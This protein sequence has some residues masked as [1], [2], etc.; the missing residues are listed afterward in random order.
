MTLGIPLATGTAPGPLG[1]RYALGRQL[2]RGSSAAVFEATD[3]VLNRPVTVK[4][5]DSALAREP[6]L[7]ARFGEQCAKAA[8]LAHPHIARVLDAGFA[9]HPVEQPFVVTEP[10][11]P[12]SL[13]Q[14]LDGEGRLPLKRAVALARQLASALAYAHAQGLVHADVKPENVLLDETGR[15]AKLVDFSLSFVSAATGMVTPATIA[16]RAAYLAPEQVR[17]E[18]VRP[19]TD[20]YGLGVLL[21]EMVAGRPPFRAGTPEATAERRIHEF[22]PPAGNFDPAIPQR[23]EA[24]LDRALERAP[25]RRWR[26]MEAFDAALA[27]LDGASL[28]PAALPLPPDP[29][30]TAAATQA[31]PWTPT[32][33]L[34]SVV[35]VAVGL[36]V[37]VLALVV[38]LRMIGSG[39]RLSNLLSVGAAQVEIPDL[40]GMSVADAKRL[41]EPRGYTFQVVGERVSDRYPKGAIVQQSPVAGWQ[42]APNGPLRV[43]VSSGPVAP[44]PL[45]TAAPAAGGTGG[46]AAGASAGACS[47]GAPPV[48][49]LGFAELK[50][51]VGAPMG[52]PLEC[53][54]ANPR[55]GDT[56]QRT[57][58][59][60][61]YYR[62]TTNLVAFTDG[63]RHWALTENGLVTWEG[64][65]PDPPPAP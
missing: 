12:R 21:Y 16:R 36:G 26:S 17:G 58:T 18:P 9:Q 20:V 34:P 41:V 31:R 32:L 4:V 7:R 14:V 10:A 64:D 24:V 8:R 46:Q 56:E 65:S 5:F 22:A 2:G 48:F 50:R 61:A 42:Q 27:T 44:G 39:P 52:E 59:G 40:V 35:L 62:R 3:L 53:E 47:P 33:R 28:T 63:W 30:Q 25:E 38:V 11:G 15:Q 45:A 43:T 29:V 13:R 55:T 57:S 37:L 60:L 19:T 6:T 23:L 54:R 51:Q 49:V 1:G